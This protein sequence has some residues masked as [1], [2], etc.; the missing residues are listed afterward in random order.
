MRR[1]DFDALQ[2]ER[3]QEVMWGKTFV[4]LV[5]LPGASEIHRATVSDR[6]SIRTVETICGLHETF[7]A[8]NGRGKRG[9]RSQVF[10]ALAAEAL[11]SGTVRRCDNCERRYEA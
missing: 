10:S 5:V 9:A 8:S 4:A 3:R 11:T 7:S 1:S 6:G 2:E